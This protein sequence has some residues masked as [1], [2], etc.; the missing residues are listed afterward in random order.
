[1]E[2]DTYGR[3]T[4]KI[5]WGERTSFTV[6]PDVDLALD[7]KEDI[8]RFFVEVESDGLVECAT[9][10]H[11]CEGIVRLLSCYEQPHR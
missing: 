2:E 1:M 4:G 3:H 10:S 9:C 7:A 11:D 5:S 8:V 6:G